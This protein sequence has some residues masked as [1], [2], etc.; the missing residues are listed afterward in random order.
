MLGAVADRK[1][2]RLAMCI[3]LVGFVIA[4]SFPVY[5]N[6][7][8]AREL[9]GYRETQVGVVGGDEGSEVSGGREKGAL[10][11]EVDVRGTEKI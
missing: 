5:L 11:E 7:V 6:L 8:K 1:G 4:W 2:T 9:D 10:A 3:P